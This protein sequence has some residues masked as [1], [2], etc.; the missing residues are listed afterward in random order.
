MEIGVKYSNNKLI[1]RVITLLRAISVGD[2]IILVTFFLSLLILNPYIRGD[3][4][5][6]YAYLRSIVIDHDLKFEN[7]FQHADP[8]FKEYVFEEDGELRPIMKMP[9][10]YVRNQWATG[11]SLLWS[12]F[13]VLIHGVV[14]FANLL[15]GQIPA[16][17]YSAPYRWACSLATVIY[18]FIGLILVY[19]IAEKFTDRRC[20]LL[21]TLAIWFASPLPVYMYFLPFH[22]PALASFTVSLLIWYWLH[23]SDRKGLKEWAIWGGIGGFVVSV[24]YLDAIFILIPFAEWMKEFI[25]ALRSSH[26]ANKI[27]EIFLKGCLFTLSLVLVLM[28]N[29]II[30][31]IIHGSPLN[32]GYNDEFFWSSPRLWQVA[33]SSEHGM[34]VWTP[35]ILF[36]IFGLFLFVR[37][38]RWIGGILVVIFTVFYYFVACYQNWHGQSS[39]GNRFFVAFTPVFVIGTAV[40]INRFIKLFSK[41]PNSG[42]TAK[43]ANQNIRNPLI[44]VA[45]ILIVMIFWNIGFIYQWGTNIIP[46]RGEVDFT[47]VAKNQVT[48]VPRK[49]I[50]FII[51][52]MKSRD[53]VTKEVEQEDLKEIPEYNL[54]R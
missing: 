43:V 38:E 13:Y 50:G 42:S 3:G 33:F 5:G 4:N 30:K 2:R 6:Y 11:S 46:S 18:A 26:R 19:R 49:M 32:T 1:S 21:A 23:R 40:S 37:S 47:K 29:F 15:G 44:A 45:V 22:V 16:D 53:Q 9:T 39:F 48:I 25:A 34:L 20:A 31:W 54:R 10:G 12:P 17:G 35:V 51:R 41:A 7:E 36:A 8:A 14:G 28:P 52:Y 27:R 24:Y